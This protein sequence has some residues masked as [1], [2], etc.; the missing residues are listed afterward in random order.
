[1]SCRFRSKT[2]TKLRQRG[3]MTARAA[4]SAAA[5]ELAAIEDLIINFQ[6]CL[7]R[8]SD[9]ASKETSGAFGDVKDCVSEALE[10]RT[11]A[12]KRIRCHQLGRRR[13]G[14]SRQRRIQEA[15]QRGRAAPAGRAGL[16]ARIGFFGWT[17]EPA[18]EQRGSTTRPL[19]S[20][21]IWWHACAA[22]RLPRWR[23]RTSRC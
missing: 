21:T 9:T 22:A 18:P 14:P 10:Y 16:P 4:K 2:H 20:P 1:M 3:Q 7:R 12:R 8:L 23:R 15:D 19:W 6:K 5:E 17:G 13:N 11:G